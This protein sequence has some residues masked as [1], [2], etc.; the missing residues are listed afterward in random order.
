MHGHGAAKGD[1]CAGAGPTLA[2]SFRD[3]IP[4][5]KL[6]S[7]RNAT[8]PKGLRPADET[9]SS[10]RQAAAFYGTRDGHFKA[11]RLTGGKDLCKFKVGSG[12]AGNPMTYVNNAK[13]YVGVLSGAGG[14]VVIKI[15]ADLK[16]P[17]DGFSPMAHYAWLPR[18]VKKR[19]QPCRLRAAVRECITQYPARSAQPGE[20][21]AAGK[22]QRRPFGPP[23]LWLVSA[24]AKPTSSLDEVDFGREIARDLEA[25]FLL[26]HGRL[27][28]NLHGISSIITLPY[29]GA[30]FLSG[31][32]GSGPI[33]FSMRSY[34]QL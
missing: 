13:P 18:F 7:A 33:E 28:P 11:K 25:N 10:S 5:G 16:G 34:Q 4:R 8:E 32:I 9:F 2:Q 23:C 27:R 17:T 22:K 1:V 20:S 30:A 19:R 3:F 31:V 26:A 14:L 29:L 6:L 15:T 24:Q 12:I 21:G